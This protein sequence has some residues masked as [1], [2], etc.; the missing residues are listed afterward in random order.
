MRGAW[1]MALGWLM[2]GVLVGCA[3]QDGGQPPCGNRSACPRGQSCIDDRCEVPDQ[4]SPIDMRII[5]AFALPDMRV[6]DAAVDARVDGAFDAA[7]DAASDARIDAAVDASTDAVVDAAPT[8]CE[9]G[10]VR[11]CGRNV[12]LCRRGREACVAGQWGPCE[13]GVEPRDEVCNGADDDCNGTVDDGFGVAEVCDGVGACGGGVTE[14]RN[15]ILTRCSSDP[16]G[17]MDASSDEA[18]NSADDDCDGRVDEGLGVGDVCD[19]ACGAGLRECAP[20]GTIVCS[21]DEGGS[22]DVAVAETCSGADDDCDGAIDE[23]FDVG[24]ACNGVGACGAGVFECRAGMAACS[25]DT[26]GSADEAVV[27]VCDGRDEDCD[28]GIDEG[29]DVGAACD[30]V[31]ACGA[32]VAECDGAGAG[33]CSSDPGAS[34]PQVRVETCNQIDDD[35]DGTEDEGFEPGPEACN[36]VDDDCDGATDE[37]AACGGDRCETAPPFALGDAR[38]GSTIDLAND[39][40]RSTC[41]GPA[42]GRDQVFSV[43]FPAAGSYLVG[44]APLDAGFDPLFWIG[45]DCAN[46]TNCLTPSAG[47]NLNGPGRPEVRTIAIPRAGDFLLVI[48]A[49]QDLAGGQFVAAVRPQA[50]GERCGTAIA[51]SVPGRSVGSTQGRNNDVSSDVCPVGTRSTGDDEVYRLDL[52]AAERLRI[53]V[54]PTAEADPVV[55]IT[56]DCLAVNAMTCA[57]GVNAGGAGVT[58]TLD[59]DLAAGAWFLVVDHARSPGAFML[60]VQRR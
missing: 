9:L 42:P 48:D 30:G 8:D 51:L 17:T 44:V 46:M 1:L 16:G 6:L 21:T 55:Y 25:T 39:Y 29:F 14:C 23:G 54:T 11:D 2:P 40:E 37:G 32:G 35:C 26:G 41:T 33:R 59:V 47:R 45:T 60:D 58:E 10:T 13:G 50:E 28:G 31:G 24:A 15:T 57:G 36:G 38:S 49:A 56:S 20:D 22:G 7:P 53:T 3:G 27:E 19:G 5:D 43:S 4:G 34:A 18:C 12:G 52:A